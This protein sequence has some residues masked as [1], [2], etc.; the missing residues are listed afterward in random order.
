MKPSIPEEPYK[1]EPVKLDLNQDFHE[2]PLKNLEEDVM[3]NTQ[4]L[5]LAGETGMSK[6][7]VVKKKKKK[8]KKG[9][10]DSSKGMD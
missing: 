5:A 10:L 8:K 2:I 4:G 3:T 6:R 9:G 1:P 7:K